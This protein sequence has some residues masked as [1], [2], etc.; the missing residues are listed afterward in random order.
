MIKPILGNV[1][2][3]FKSRAT[4]G[5]NLVVQ[6]PDLDSIHKSEES[7]KLRSP[8]DKYLTMDLEIDDLNPYQSND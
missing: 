2:N 4:R 8:A 5:I 3:L 7:S 6:D 1:K